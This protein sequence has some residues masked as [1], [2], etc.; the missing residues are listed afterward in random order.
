MPQRPWGN[1]FGDDRALLIPL[2]SVKLWTGLLGDL[3]SNFDQSLKNCACR[4]PQ[5]RDE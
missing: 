2:A 5:A 4:C 3:V 1:A